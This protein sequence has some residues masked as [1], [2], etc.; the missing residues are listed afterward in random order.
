MAALAVFAKLPFVGILM[1]GIAIGKRYS[2]KSGIG[3][4]VFCL[5]LM[6]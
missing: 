5:L 2:G 4:A 3:L 6:T 1:A